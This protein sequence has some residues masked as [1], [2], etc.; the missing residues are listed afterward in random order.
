MRISPLL[1]LAGVLLA[2]WVDS[3]TAF[4]QPSSELSRRTLPLEMTGDIASHLVAGADRFLLAKLEQS[5]ENRAKHW[6]RDLSSPENYS[7][8]LE[9]NRKRLAHILGVRDPRVRYSS[10]ELMA[11]VR[12]PARVGGT[13]SYDIFS[14]RWP[15]IGQIHGEGLLLVPRQSRHVADVI[16]VPDADQSPEQLAG[17]VPGVPAASQFARR[18]VESGC[19]VVVPA[20]ISRDTKRR[21][22]R[23]YL[24]HREFIYRS[25]FELGR[26]LLGYEIQKILALVDWFTQNAEGGDRTPAPELRQQGDGGQDVVHQHE[27][28]GA[29]LDFALA[30]RQRPARGLHR[31]EHPR[32]GAVADCLR[33]NQ[34]ENS[35]DRQRRS[36]RKTGSGGCR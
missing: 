22:G 6:N 14:I 8:S 13:D 7:R 19:R 31:F 28:G 4:G 36:S 33:G 12:T 24:T 26:H 1:L 9:P 5:R 3:R 25:A 17:L 34:K 27:A 18:L 10:P 30:G 15:S 2:P 16:A 23:P 21:I 20:L 32:C 29:P 11:T 35:L